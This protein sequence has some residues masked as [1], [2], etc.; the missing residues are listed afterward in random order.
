VDA[1]FYPLEV[2][3][4]K[5]EETVRHVFELAGSEAITSP[6]TPAHTSMTCTKRKQ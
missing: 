5:W 1:L 4:R 2:S 3:S 6:T